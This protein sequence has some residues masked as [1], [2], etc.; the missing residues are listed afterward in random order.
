MKRISFALCGILL[1]GAC[2]AQGLGNGSGLSIT[3]GGGGGGSLVGGTTPIT[4]V[5]PNGQLL[6]NNAGILGC[7]ASGGVSSVSNS[8]GTL[9][10]SPTTGAVVASIALG[11]ANT[12]T[13]QQTFVAPVLGAASLTSAQFNGSLLV[14]DAANILSLR[15]STTAQGSRNYNT[16]TS[17][18]IGEWGYG[19][20]W[21]VTANLC[22]YGT[23]ANGSGSPRGFVFKTANLSNVFDFN[24]TWT[25]AFNFSRGIAVGGNFFAGSGSDVGVA[26]GVHLGFTAAGLPNPASTND[27]Y[28]TSPSTGVMLSSGTLGATAAYSA[29]TPPTGTTGSCSATSFSG[30]P[31]AGKFTAPSCVAGTIILSA[32]PAQTTGYACDAIDQ[33]TPADTLKQTASTT[34]SVTFAATTA[35][36]DAVVFKCI[37]Y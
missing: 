30:G 12:W 28:F 18:S 4:G 31:A 25:N 7:Q 6:Y 20:D 24:N 5:C 37:G 22:T 35:A 36:S 19:C 23:D 17:S 1:S 16:Y 3:G 27:T 32:L 26:R 2:W 29:G 8:D 21:T 33:T 13:G 15:N 34:T 10:I 11:H 14:T 9:T